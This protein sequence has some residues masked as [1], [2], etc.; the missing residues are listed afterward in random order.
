MGT[1]TFSFSGLL[2]G[3]AQV[4]DPKTLILMLVGTAVGIVFGAIPGISCNMAV[5]LFLPMTFGMDPYLAVALLIAVYIGGMSG[6]LIS[7]VL[8]NIPGTPASIAT[9]FDGHP[10]AMKGQSGRAL[11][12]GILTSFVGGLISIV[13]LMWLSPVLAN[14]ALKFG[15]F[16]YFSI[17]V[18]SLVLIGTVSGKS[19]VKG[20]I[21][22]LFGLCLSCVGL[23][24]MTKAPRMTWGNHVLDTGIGVIPLLVG[25]FAIPELIRFFV[26]GA[27]EEYETYPYKKVKGFGIRFLEYIQH[28]KNIIVSALI[29]VG[30]GILPGIG[31]N[32]SNLLAYIAAKNTSKDPDKFGTGCDDGIIASETANNA[33]IGGAFVTMLALGIPGSTTTAILMSALTLHG[34]A[35]G[36]TLFINYPALIYTIF[37]A[38]LIGN[39]M[40]IIIERGGLNVFTRLLQIPRYILMP[41]VVL[42]C[43]V[44]A[45]VSNK[46][47]F[48][49]G[50]MVVFGVVAYFLTEAGFPMTPL[51]I[52]FIIGPIVEINLQRALMSY[53]MSMVPYFTRPISCFFFLATV[54]S[55]VVMVFNAIKDARAKKKKDTK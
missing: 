7:A 3:F 34:F 9:A 22:A 5:V 44:G 40:M 32:V 17:G 27:D 46:S 29:G 31:G 43:I 30:I 24:Q 20:L 53:Q 8:L 50:C 48:D 45:Y 38:L 33:C 18:F 10:M 6:G 52:A 13:F 39:V 1:F 42:M 54:L 23:G 28:W 2:T 26:K 11:G 35:P 25:I 14:Y 36:P 41:L 47:V 21:S 55:V 16:E 49:V 51:I 19:K 4:A 12:I 15:P 37:A